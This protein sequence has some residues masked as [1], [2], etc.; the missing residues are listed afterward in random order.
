[1]RLRVRV[2]VRFRVTIRFRVRFRFRVR[3]RARFRIRIRVGLR[4]RVMIPYWGHYNVLGSLT[5]LALLYYIRVII[6]YPVY[7][8]ILGF[9]LGL[10]LR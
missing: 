3:A 5:I 10:H 9:G 8:T 4:I 7:Y 6:L 1:M 2:T